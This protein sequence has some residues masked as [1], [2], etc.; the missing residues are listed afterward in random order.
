MRA[1]KKVFGGLSFVL[2]LV[3]GLL[4]P[5]SPAYAEFQER[6]AINDDKH[7]TMALGSTSRTFMIPTSKPDGLRVDRM[8]VG[9]EYALS[10]SG[11]FTYMVGAGRTADAECAQDVAGDGLSGRQWKAKRWSGEAQGAFEDLFDIRVKQGSGFQYLDW[12][13]TDPYPPTMNAMTDITAAGDYGESRCS[14]THTY[15]AKFIPTYPQISLSVFD[16]WKPADNSGELR[17]TLARS[18]YVGTR[19]YDCPK[20]LNDPFLSV[21]GV[22][23]GMES[24]QDHPGSPANSRVVV[25]EIETAAVMVQAHRDGQKT[26]FPGALNFGGDTSR[27]YYPRTMRFDAETGH[28]GIYTCNY[29]MPDATYKIVVDGTFT[30]NSSVNYYDSRLAMADAECTTGLET[31]DTEWKPQRFTELRN[32]VPY[33][34]EDLTIGRDWVDWKPVV[35]TNGDGCADDANHTYEV[36]FSPSTPGPLL[37]KI[38]DHAY[39]E[40][41]NFG[42]LCME[43]YKLE[44]G[45]QIANLLTGDIHGEH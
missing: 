20:W 43:V 1:R 34:F 18:P 28:D 16:P 23:D 19:T 31:G 9:S 10:I 17:I 26:K 12:I 15:T 27:P 29:G 33:D 6:S 42:A 25:G 21:P 4:N 41:N 3:V 32:G 2:V 8:I 7:E 36:I 45:R 30:F 22:P 35:D 11:T 38:V 39:K 40:S 5:A 13:P 37:F 14:S 44:G 24:G